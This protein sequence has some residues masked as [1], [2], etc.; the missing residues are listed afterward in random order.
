MFPMFLSDVLLTHYGALQLR[1]F[2]PLQRDMGNKTGIKHQ[3][4][5]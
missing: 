2:Q 1:L 3:Q 4:D 5:G